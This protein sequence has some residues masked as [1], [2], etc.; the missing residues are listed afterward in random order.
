MFDKECH[1]Q[2]LGQ[3]VHLLI[4]SVDLV[5][6]DVTLLNVLVEMMELYVEMLGAWSDLV[7]GHNLECAAVVFKDFAVHSRLGRLD[8]ESLISNF[9]KFHKRNGLPE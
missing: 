6:G 9:V 4:L 7:Y 1:R 2:A 3:D 8:V 5:N